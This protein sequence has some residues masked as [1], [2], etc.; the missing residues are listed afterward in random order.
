MNLLNNRT[1]VND[2]ILKNLFIQK[3]LQEEAQEI[4]KAQSSLMS[5]RGFTSPEFFSDRNFAVNQTTLTYSHLQK[6]RFVDMKTRQ[7]NNA[8]IKKASH[9]IHNRIIFGHLNNIIK[10]MHFGYTQAVK[11]QMQE[12][13]N[14]LSK[15]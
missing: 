14:N 13:Y 10:R 5:S 3:Q 4:D 2:D 11:E 9:P 6:H 1:K 8:K 12:L 7:V 15:K